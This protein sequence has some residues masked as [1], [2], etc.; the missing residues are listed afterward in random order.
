MKAKLLSLAM[1]LTITLTGAMGFANVANAAN[2]ADETYSF[3]NVNTEG[4]TRWRDKTNSTKVY[5]YPQEGP[6]LYY[7]VHGCNSVTPS[8]WNVRSS[9]VQIPHGVQG[10]ITNYINENNENQARLKLERTAVGSVVSSGVWSPDSTK[11][12]TI[13]N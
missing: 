6:N 4:T 11:N 1:A 13:F 2:V 12:Y 10:S 7:T 8:I 5:V 9:R 3:Y